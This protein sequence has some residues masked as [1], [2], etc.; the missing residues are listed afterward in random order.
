MSR[1]LLKLVGDKNI[2]PNDLD[3]PRTNHT[4]SLSS[5]R[6]KCIGGHRASFGRA[7]IILFI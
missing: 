5:Y 4:T 6:V 2:V 7:S 3:Q 1:E